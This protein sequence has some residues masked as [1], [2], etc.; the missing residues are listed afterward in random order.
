MIPKVETVSKWECPLCRKEDF[1]DGR[2]L[3]SGEVASR[4]HPCPSLGLM[5][6]PMIPAGTKAKI[7]A[8]ERG[9]YVGKEIIQT[10]AYGRPIMSI[11]VERPDGSNDT[12]V[13]APTSVMNVNA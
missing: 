7:T 10:D 12:V 8:N 2:R 1:T 11:T 9:D 6:T 4:F 3:K 5:L 13:F